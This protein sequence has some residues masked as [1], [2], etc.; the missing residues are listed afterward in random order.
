MRKKKLAKTNSRKFPS[1]QKEKKRDKVIDLNKKIT[2]K[3]ADSGAYQNE[4][5]STMNFDLKKKRTNPII[6]KKSKEEKRRTDVP[7]LPSVCP[8][9]SFFYFAVQIT[10]DC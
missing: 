4:S 5:I 7:F 3:S 8:A 10:I 9:V 2:T 1:I 6:K